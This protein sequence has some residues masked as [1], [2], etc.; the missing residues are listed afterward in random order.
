MF[1]IRGPMSG[2]ASAGIGA[3]PRLT[4]Q[5]SFDRIC[6]PNSTIREAPKTDQAGW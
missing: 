2:D 1:Q 6:A 4:S 5:A 3:L